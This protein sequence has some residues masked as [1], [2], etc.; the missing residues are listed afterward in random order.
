VG[1]HP[2]GQWARRLGSRV[3]R[4]PRLSLSHSILGIDVVRAR[5]PIA[6]TR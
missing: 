1:S 3:Q 2:T 4:D 6:S 5:R